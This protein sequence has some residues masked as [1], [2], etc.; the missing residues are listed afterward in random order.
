MEQTESAVVQVAPYDENQKLRERKRCRRN[1]QVRQA[2]DQQNRS[3]QV[4]KLVSAVPFGAHKITFQ[5][6][7]VEEAL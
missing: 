7:R 5:F 2:A 4:T 6:S 1:L 3:A